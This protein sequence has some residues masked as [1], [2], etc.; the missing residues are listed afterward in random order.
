VKFS[1]QFTTKQPE[2]IQ[3]PTTEVEAIDGLKVID[4]FV[5]ESCDAL[6]GSLLSIKGHCQR[7]HGWTE[8]KGNNF[9]TSELNH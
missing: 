4:G 6:Y 7:I 1:D 9:Y 5:C 8:S 3:S 2:E